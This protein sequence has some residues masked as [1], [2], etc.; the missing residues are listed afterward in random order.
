MTAVRHL[1][2]KMNKHE[3][4]KRFTECHTIEGKQ[5]TQKAQ[6]K[7]HLEKYGKITPMAA[8]HSYGCMRCASRIDELRK[9]G[10]N[11]TTN[12]VKSPRG[13]R[14]AEYELLKVETSLF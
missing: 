5:I 4:F 11:I 8:L 3:E 14:H 9:E 7:D 12:M 13:K 10:L 2:V 6:I 1:G